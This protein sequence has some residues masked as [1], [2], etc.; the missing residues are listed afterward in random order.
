MKIGF[1][2]MFTAAQ[3]PWATPGIISG[4]IISGWQGAVVQLVVVAATV[5]VFIPSLSIG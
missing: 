1:M 2:P 4:I 3:A 5:V